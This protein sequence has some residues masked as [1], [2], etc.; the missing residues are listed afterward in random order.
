[1]KLPVRMEFWGDE[2]DT[3]HTFDLATQRREDPVEKIY[4]SPAREVLFRAPADAAAL[5]RAYATKQ[6]GTK[7]AALDA[8]MASDL[9]Q[10]DGGALPVVLDKYLAVRYPAPATLLDHLDDPLLV[11]EEPASLR[12]AQ[13][14]TAYRRGEEL[15]ALL[16]D[17]ALAPGL[18]A[19][20]A[21]P[22]WLWAQPARCRTICAETFARRRPD[23]RLKATVQA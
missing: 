12:E 11:L 6:R 14:A 16:A 3:M 7:R 21:E 15:T 4:V 8:C 19:L 13:R 1:I 5:L 17:G 18:D 9:A 22:G 20:Y 23:R 10:L 2:I